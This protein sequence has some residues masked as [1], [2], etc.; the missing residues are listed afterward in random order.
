[1]IKYILIVVINL[2]NV[3]IKILF[4]INSS[5]LMNC[6]IY[7]IIFLRKYLAEKYKIMR[8]VNF[9]LISKILRKIKKISLTVKK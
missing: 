6:V 8:K 9:S 4:A 2:K 1:V 7:K 3:K 5:K